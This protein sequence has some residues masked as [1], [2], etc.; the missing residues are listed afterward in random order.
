MDQIK[1]MAMV[2]V[3]AGGIGF[4]AG[5]KLMPTKIVETKEVQVDKVQKD[6]VTVVK[7]ITLPNGE[8]QVVTTTTDKSIENKEISHVSSK[9]PLKWHVAAL[10]L[11][12]NLESPE[13]YAVQA[14]KYLTDNLS[15]GIQVSSNR[16]VGLVLGLTF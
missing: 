3:L 14:E 10:V 16:N 5:H 1:V 8:K 12:S 9:Q 11:K 4:F 15:L 2:I 7:E 6:I 13:V